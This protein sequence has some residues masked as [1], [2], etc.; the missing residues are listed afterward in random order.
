MRTGSLCLLFQE[1]HSR[2]Q[3]GKYLKYSDDFAADASRPCFFG[4]TSVPE[5]IKAFI[6]L[7]IIWNSGFQNILCSV[8]G[9]YQG[10]LPD[11]NCLYFL[12]S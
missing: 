4:L 8:F 3:L 6:I 1:K 2:K 5:C 9:C 10:M 7:E 11:N 12:N